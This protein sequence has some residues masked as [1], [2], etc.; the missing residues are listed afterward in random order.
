MVPAS[1]KGEKLPLGFWLVIAAGALLRVVGI[2][3]GL[4]AVFNSD[5]PHLVN[6]A[7]SF[8]KGSLRPEL[9]KYPTL[10]PYLLFASYG[11]LFVFWSGFGLVRGVSDFGGFFA[12]TPMPFFLLGRSLAAAASLAALLPVYR[13]ARTWLGQTGA[14]SAAGLLAVSPVIVEAAHASKPEGLMLCWAAFAWAFAAAYL[15]DGRRRDLALAGAMTGL[16]LATQYTAAPLSSMVVAAWI[17]RRWRNADAAL[18]A[19]AWAIGAAVLAFAVGSPYNLIDFP[20]FWSAMADVRRL[21]AAGAGIGPWEVG[22]GMITFAGPWLPGLALAI[23]AAHLWRTDRPRLLWLGAPI[24]L[25]L[26]FFSMSSE[27]GWPRYSLGVYPALALLA[28]AGFEAAVPKLPAWGV[29]TAVAVFLLPGIWRSAAYDRSVLLPD[30]RTLSTEWVEANIPEGK[31]LLLDQEFASPRVKWDRAT[32]ER[33]L[34]RTREENH[35]RARYFQYMLNGH[36]GGGYGVYRVPRDFKDLHSYPGH[37]AFSQLAQPILDVREG[38]KAAKA[39]GVDFVVLTSF[40]ADEYRS[41]ELADFLSQVRQ[42]GQPVAVFEPA[43]GRIMGPRIEIYRLSSNGTLNGTRPQ[44]RAR[45]RAPGR[46][47]KPRKHR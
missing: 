45:A 28:A 32:V 25:T 14:V 24:L 19:L 5:E 2:G 11:A 29:A 34:A 36:P 31:T 21:E 44:K 27:G 38:L 47:S 39:A 40:G 1:G 20:S 46:S 17:A 12:W 18:S 15:V 42:D 30:T 4:P 26:I 23:G 37:V 35:P 16:A 10:F 7:V 13:A 8:G 33:L 9:F 3:Y 6:L 43:E 41:P 22:T